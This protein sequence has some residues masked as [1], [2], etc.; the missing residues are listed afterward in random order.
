MDWLRPLQPDAGNVMSS[1]CHSIS[2]GDVLHLGM[3]DYAGLV[4][5]EREKWNKK[6]YPSSR[7]R[8]CVPAATQAQTCF[9]SHVSVHLCCLALVVSTKGRPDRGEISHSTGRTGSVDL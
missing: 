7:E 2:N 5:R 3:Q 8:R 1:L 4:G 9:K 6:K